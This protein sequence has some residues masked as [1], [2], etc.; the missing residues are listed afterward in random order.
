VRIAEQVEAL[1]RAAMKGKPEDAV[2]KVRI[3]LNP[4][5]HSGVFDHPRSEAATRPTGGLTSPLDAHLLSVL[6]G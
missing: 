4:I 6:V 3:P 2:S 1:A 5:S